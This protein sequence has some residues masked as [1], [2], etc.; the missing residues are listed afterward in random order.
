MLLA[1]ITEQG[2]TF[3]ENTGESPDEFARSIALAIKQ[4]GILEDGL[5]ISWLD[6]KRARRALESAHMV[7]AG[8][9]RKA[10]KRSRT[11]HELWTANRIYNNPKVRAWLKKERL[12]PLLGAI[13]MLFHDGVENERAL[14]RERGNAFKIEEVLSNMLDI[15]TDGRGMNRLEN[16]HNIDTFFST[17]HYM[18]DGSKLNKS[19]RYETQYAKSYDDGVLSIN[20]LEQAARFYDKL[21]HVVLDASESTQGALT[22]PEA[23][24]FW[25]QSMLKIFVL[26]F[27][28]V[29]VAEKKEY[30]AAANTLKAAAK[31]SPEALQTELEKSFEGHPQ[32]FQSYQRV[33]AS[34]NRWRST[35]TIPS[36]VVEP[37]RV[38][39]L[40]QAAHAG[41]NL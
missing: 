23:L 39:A 17:L 1:P 16:P 33:M 25:L 34:L 24:K 9:V 22:P 20:I 40:P 18:T 2:V 28:L 8:K 7:H 15:L 19:L 4:S 5:D 27:Q 21:S 31:L 12:D 41:L 3:V 32:L 30:M 38:S 6:Q 37:S 29:S 13:I 14:A 11:I 36:G 26:E 10:G 35:I